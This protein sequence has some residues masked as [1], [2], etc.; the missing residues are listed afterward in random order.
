LNSFISACRLALLLLLL[1]KLCCASAGQFTIE[2]FAEKPGVCVSGAVCAAVPAV[3][4]HRLAA[5]TA[6]Q[7]H[8]P[9]CSALPAVTAACARESHL[10]LPALTVKHA[11]DVDIR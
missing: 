8:K 5:A 6:V 11:A 2:R 1:L 9:L 4:S 3:V 7:E 10:W